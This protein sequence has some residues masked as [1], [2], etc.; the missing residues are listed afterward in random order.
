MRTCVDMH[1]LVIVFQSQEALALAYV[2]VYVVCCAVATTFLLNYDFTEFTA[3]LG[4]ADGRTKG[5]GAGLQYGRRKWK[6]ATCMRHTAQPSTS[7]LIITERIAKR[8]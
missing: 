4:M 5:N 3:K 2:Y 7:T 8:F 6:W 1:Q